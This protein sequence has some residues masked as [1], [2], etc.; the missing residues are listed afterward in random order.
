MIYATIYNQ[1]DQQ[2]I[3]NEKF[4]LILEP[5]SYKTSS[6]W[7]NQKLQ[8]DRTAKKEV[9]KTSSCVGKK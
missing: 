8:T 7:S 1:T 9:Q 3:K 2:R 4:E 6:L 5:K